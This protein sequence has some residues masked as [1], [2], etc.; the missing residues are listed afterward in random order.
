MS[1][2]TQYDINGE[3]QG[4]VTLN[5]DENFQANHQ[6]IKEYIVALRENQR[7]WSA[8]TK[9]RSEV[10][11]SRKKCRPQKG[12]GNARQG[13]TTTPQFKGGGIVFGPKPKFDQ[14]VKVNRKE[15]RAAIRFL[16]IEKIK[17]GNLIVLKDPTGELKAPKTKMIDTLLKKVEAKDKRTLFIAGRSSEDSNDSLFT[18]LSKSIRNIPKAKLNQLAQMSGYDLICNKMLIVCESEMAQL[19]QLVE[20]K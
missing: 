6:M 10:K 5:I 19:Q 8:N 3:K 20:S 9:T 11:A 16:L 12:T 1:N 13:N 18:N 7:Q 4:E 17:S 2:I 15:K 14:H